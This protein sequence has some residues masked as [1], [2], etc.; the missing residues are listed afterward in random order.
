M[1]RTISIAKGKGSIGHN[2]R[3]FK[4]EN[5]DPERT[6][7]N[8]CYVNEDIH[9]VYHKLFDT[10]L[11]DY[12]AKQKR[13]DRKIPNYYEKI[14]T[15]KQEK[16]FYE[17]IVQV[18]NFE[19]MS[20]TDEIG[21][22]AEEIL[23]KYMADFQ[24]RNPT[25][26]VFSAHLHMD[27]AT[28]HLHIDFVPYTDG[29]KRGLGTK[30]TLKGALEKLGFKGGARG[31]TELTQWQD[32]EKEKLAEIMLE[33]DINWEKK[34]SNKEHLSVLDYKKEKRAEEIMQLE[35]QIDSLE[36]NSK[37]LDTIIE[38][39]TDIAKRIEAKLDNLMKQ[40]KDIQTNIHAYYEETEW[41]LPEVT[42]FATAKSYKEKKAQP[43][44]NSLK[45]V[46]KG[47]VVRLVN[48]NQKYNTLLK[49][50]NY[51]YD[52]ANRV[53]KLHDTNALK[54]ENYM[55]LEKVLGKSKVVALIQ[56]YQQK[57]VPLITKKRDYER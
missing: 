17:I 29:N 3:N 42:G 25:L 14:R 1:K 4:A 7:F 36:D 44:V 21:K 8:T 16:L 30:N 2:S 22:I 23:H 12:N 39:K 26:F 34:G 43:L 31:S 11:E 40:H 19:D 47:L 13:N 41:Q 24:Q 9:Q 55:K 33:Y 48:L 5:V 35:E 20:A 6:Q 45:E 15:S 53:S 49:E 50:K 56:E 18:G 38:Q 46:I 52:K 32:S 37:K 28:P 57:P 27:E 51:W 10:A 54:A